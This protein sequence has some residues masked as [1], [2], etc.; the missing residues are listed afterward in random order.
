MLSA[1]KEMLHLQQAGQSILGDTIQENTKIATYSGKPTALFNNYDEAVMSSEHIRSATPKENLDSFPNLKSRPLNTH[2]V[3]CTG[4]RET[5]GETKNL[6][7]ASLP[8]AN[9]RWTKIIRQNCLHRGLSSEA[10]P[11]YNKLDFMQIDNH[12]KL[13]NKKQQVSRSDGVLNLVVAIV[14]PCQSQRIA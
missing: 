9:S 8:S 11:C 2:P 7:H 5:H 13:P 12:S 10:L 6:T 4:S 14:Q 1:L 3:G